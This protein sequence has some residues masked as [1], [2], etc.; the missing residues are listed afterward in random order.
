MVE[1]ARLAD[2]QPG[3][4]SSKAVAWPGGGE[5]AKPIQRDNRCLKFVLPASWKP[6]VYAFRITGA[7]GTVQRLLNQPDV[8]WAQ[9][10]GGTFATPGGWVRAFGKNLSQHST[11]AVESQ[12]TILLKGPRTVSLI[13][14]ADCYALEAT[15]PKDLPLGQY[16]LWVHNGCGGEAGWSK[17]VALTLAN[18]ASWPQ[19]V[20]NVRDYGAKGNG[21]DDDSIGV[22]AALKAAATNGGGVVYFPRGRYELSQTIE[23]PRFTVLRGEKREWATIYWP[24]W[25]NPPETL[26]LGSNSFGIED[27]TLSCGN[28][29]T[30]LTTDTEGAEAGDVFLHR[31]RVRACAYRGH[32]G[33]PL[34]EENLE[35]FN[36][37]FREGLKAHFGGG[38]WLAK[39]GGRNVEVTDCDLY[40]SG[41]VISLRHPRGARIEGNTLYDGR[42]GGSGVFGGEGLIIAGNHYV[43]ADLMTWGGAGGFGFD[44]LSHLYLSGNTFS[45]QNGGDGE[46]VTTDGPGGLYHGPVAGSSANTLTLPQPPQGNQIERFTRGGAVYVVGGRGTGQWRKVIGL[47]GATLTVDR[48]W[49]TPPDASS[50]VVV[51]FLLHQLLLVDNEFSDVGRAI[52][53]YGNSIEFIVARNRSIRAGGFGSLGLPYG[54]DGIQPSWYCQFLNNTIAEGNYYPS[55]REAGKLSG[56][57]S[58]IFVYGRPPNKDWVW[59]LN[60][61]GIV[62]NNRLENNAEIRIGGSKYD[63]PIVQ[64]VVVEDNSIANSDYGIHVD[65]ATKG[66]VLRNNVFKDCI[67]PIQNG[68][69]DTWIYPVPEKFGNAKR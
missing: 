49:D 46:A 60:R 15:L 43:G 66:V 17:P 69:A 39:L 32:S 64:D 63:S 20:F 44:N 38:Y 22:I 40:S 11:G 62:R 25:D 56:G 59:P 8:W 31:I 57:D 61:G 2:G 13:V 54:K 67:D 3:D 41:C 27:L 58:P 34:K 4:P 16:Q 68:G 5:K 28:Y 18:K 24:E 30:F 9:G 12:A 35:I 48:P 1:V 50:T 47:E 14:K 53:M 65:R 55:I 6:G 26:V 7:D 23:I 10:D 45:M 42:W 21:N 19:N 37:R 29:T 33:Y 51:T 36:K 52:Q